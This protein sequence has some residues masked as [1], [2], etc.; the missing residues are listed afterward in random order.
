MIRF[1]NID[2]IKF[3]QHEL[4]ATVIDNYFSDNAGTVISVYDNKENF[5]G[6]IFDDNKEKHIVSQ[7]YLL[8]DRENLFEDISGVLEKKEG[9]FLPILNEKNEILMYAF[10]QD[11]FRYDQVRS[12]L[13]IARNSYSDIELNKFIEGAPEV[14]CIEGLNQIA[15]ELYDLLLACGC[16][17]IVKGEVWNILF[18]DEIIDNYN[19]KE[20]IY[21]YQDTNKIFSIKA[22]SKLEL[23]NIHTN[24]AIKNVGENFR[25]II[26]AAIALG[27]LQLEKVLK[28]I[29][30][31]FTFCICPIPNNVKFTNLSREFMKIPDVHN[32]IQGY[33]D[34]TS[35]D[36][37]DIIKQIYGVDS[38]P[39]KTLNETDIF[40]LS[41]AGE[42]GFIGKSSLDQRCPKRI[43]IIGPCI[44]R[45]YCVQDKATIS[46]LIQE[47]VLEFG[48]EV[49]RIV[50]SKVNWLM[51][52]KL[53]KL[54]IRSKDI[55]LFISE[56]DSFPLVENANISYWNVNRCYE[57]MGEDQTTYYS[58]CA[59]HLNEK[60]HRKLYN[61][62]YENYL[63]SLII[64]LS[65]KDNNSYIQ[66][67]DILD[68]DTIKL[69]NQYADK[70]VID[71]YGKVGALVMNCNPFT[72][73]HRYIIEKA[74]E[75]MD[76]VYVFVVQEDKSYF[77]FSDRYEMVKRGT[78][79]ISNVRVLPSGQYVLSYNT[80]PSYFEK[81]YKK[82][83]IIDASKD[84]E[85]FARYV[86]PRFKIKYRFVG[87]EIKDKITRQYNEQMKVLCAEFGIEVIEMERKK[88][89]DEIISASTVR[90]AINEK[91]WDVVK[92]ML[93]DT[94]YKYLQQT[95]VINE[96]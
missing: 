81:E 26:K 65:K 25:P 88:A 36:E 87:E 17:C 63:N 13:K 50:V 70:Y 82:E 21:P 46:N 9:Q 32:K 42:D 5:I 31:R 64:K 38:L 4:T 33:C 20:N 77:S 95:N 76:W 66:K 67:G 60:G 86:A 56:E 84:I 10:E 28:K 90:K 94:T 75:K 16:K 73:G 44:V 35:D 93:P 71:T 15:Y 34:Y 80:L 45:G 53:E 47:K 19:D 54:P 14:I 85:I 6:C 22:E 74:A 7:R 61:Y 37:R 57:E 52:D 59:I 62:I 89:T 39:A 30:N 27:R 12:F 2:T 43:Y 68:K 79:D 29:D 1:C 11:D 41:G 48:Y 92:Q 83:V 23:M 72:K 8:K 55:V 78:Q 40:N 24:R 18:G 96:L 49:V 51:M 69:I 91:N 3:Y 58:D